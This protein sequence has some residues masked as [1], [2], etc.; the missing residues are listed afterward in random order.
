MSVAASAARRNPILARPRR[1]G[2]SRGLAGRACA[3]VGSGIKPHATREVKAMSLRKAIP[4]VAVLLAFGAGPAF[5]DDAAAKKWIDNE[6]QPSTL[7][8]EDQLKEMQW[9]AKAATPFKGY[10]INVLSEDI[11]TH[12]YEAEVLA[13][14]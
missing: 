2:V 5:A 13:K 6:F 7:S 9:F 11:P 4:A 3:P 14:A 8:K 12:H 1:S 10:E